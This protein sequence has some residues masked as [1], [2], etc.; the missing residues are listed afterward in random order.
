MLQVK[1][2]ARNDGKRKRVL[3]KLLALV[4]TIREEAES[5]SGWSWVAEGGSGDTLF[6]ETSRDDGSFGGSGGEIV[7]VIG[8]VSG[9]EGGS[10][11]ISSSSPRMAKKDAMCRHHRMI[12]NQ[13]EARISEGWLFDTLDKINVP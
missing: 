3:K 4:F 2:L 11:G 13:G 9:K 12:S 10:S 5:L 1:N 8:W 6:V 7:E